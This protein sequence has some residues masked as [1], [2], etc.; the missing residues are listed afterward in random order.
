MARTSGLTLAEIASPEN[1]TQAVERAVRGARRSPAVE[2]FLARLPQ[3][4]HE[5]QC[6]LLSETLDLGHSTEFL[7]HD[8]KPRRIAA[9]IFV[10]RVLHHAVMAFVAPV[11]ER[12]LVADTFACLRGRGALAA[13]MRAQQHAR[14]FPWYAQLDIRQYFASVNHNVLVDL[15]ERRFRNA[16]VRRL[17]EKIVRS[18]SANGRG[19]PIGSLCSQHFANTYLSRLDRVIMQETPARGMVRYMDDVVFWAD[20]RD[21]IQTSLL[22][23]REVVDSNLLLQL[24]DEPTIN[25]S[26]HGLSFCGFRIFPG[27]LRLLLRRKRRFIA[28]RRRW[29]RRYAEGLITMAELQRGYDAAAGIV[30]HA[31]SLGWRQRQL[32]LCPELDDAE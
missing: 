15:L 14:R 9:P 8:P 3:A 6:G 11:L 23:V 30:A 17:L 21:Q 7:I 16:G 22:L 24:R 26:Q 10:E 31:E 1:L 5:L 25:R 12:S 20:E 4:L 2:R 32:C 18:G 19:L 13:V 29:E 28:A 27:V